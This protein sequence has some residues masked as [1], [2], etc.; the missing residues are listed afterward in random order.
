MDIHYLESM[1]QLNKRFQDL[2]LFHNDKSFLIPKGYNNSVFLN[3]AHALVIQDLLI[4]RMSGLDT[5]LSD[6]VMLA[7]KNGSVPDGKVDFEFRDFIFDE[8]K[9]M[10]DCMARDISDVSFFSGFQSYHLSLFDY[11]LKSIED[12]FEFNKIHFSL[13][14]GYAMAMSKGLDKT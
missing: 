4:Y 6:E 2:V 8:S 9:R 1:K 5:H 10:F 12:A 13:H 14:W 7:F 11:D 3:Y